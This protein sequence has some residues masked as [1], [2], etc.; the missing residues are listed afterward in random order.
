MS[1]YDLTKQVLL[2][3]LQAAQQRQKALSDAANELAASAIHS[4]SVANNT[5]S[6]FT[7]TDASGTAAYSFNFPNELVFD[8]L[9]TTFVANFAFNS[10]T[11][12]GATDPELNGKPVLVIAIKDTNAAGTVTTTYSFLN[13]ETLV[14]IY[15]AAD[16]S[17]NINGYAVNVKISAAANNAITL[18]SDGLHVDIS[19]KAD[20]VA[21]ATEGNLAALD[22]NGNLVDSGHGIATDAEVTAMLNEIYGTPA[23]E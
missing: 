9:K 11:Y 14:D 19:G 23:G 10:T 7:S 17:I 22:A 8:Q 16:N 12:T 20:K 1:D 18:Q 15:T 21:N 13:M 3:H 4:V 6:F 5:V 2:K